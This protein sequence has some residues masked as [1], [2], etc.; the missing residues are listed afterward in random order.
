MHIAGRVATFTFAVSLSVVSWPAAAALPAPGVVTSGSYWSCGIGGSDLGLYFQYSGRIPSG[1]RVLTVTDGT[2]Y[3][4]TQCSTQ[5]YPQGM[6]IEMWSP[7]PK[8]VLHQ[9][10]SGV[11]REVVPSTGLAVDGVHRFDAS[12]STIGKA[13]TFTMHLVFTFGPDQDPYPLSSQHQVIAG[14]YVATVD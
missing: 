13:A 3:G 9:Y 10:C 2:A 7:T 4:F 8:G 11:V 5:S 6:S 14:A 12:C 1:K